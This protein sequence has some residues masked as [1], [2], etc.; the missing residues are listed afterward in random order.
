MEAEPEGSAEEWSQPDEQNI[1]QQATFDGS[2]LATSKNKTRSRASVTDEVPTNSA[3]VAR[4]IEQAA[5]AA[6]K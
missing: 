3:E 1:C 2:R 5:R 4:L 6:G